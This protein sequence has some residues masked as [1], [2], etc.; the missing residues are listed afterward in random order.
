MR[1]PP[2]KLVDAPGISHGVGPERGT[3]LGADRKDHILQLKI[4]RKQDF[5]VAPRRVYLYRVVLL[6]IIQAR[7]RIPSARR[8]LH[9]GFGKQSGLISGRRADEKEFFAIGHLYKS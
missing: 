8:K 9:G 3:K 4:K 7:R 5:I 1:S 6:R 2:K